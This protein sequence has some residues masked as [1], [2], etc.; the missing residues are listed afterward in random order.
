MIL[1][2]IFLK[3]TFKK[4]NFVDILNEFSNVFKEKNNE[5]NKEYLCNELI[6]LSTKNPI[7][8][9]MFEFRQK[10]DDKFRNIP[11]KDS[12]DYFK[13]HD[14]HIIW[15]DL[16]NFWFTYYTSIIQSQNNI[17][18]LRNLLK[19]DNN[20]NG[21]NNSLIWLNDYIKFMKENSLKIEQYK[22]FPNQMGNFEFINDL[23]Y[24][25][26]IPEILINIYNKLIYHDIRNSFLSKQITSYKNCD[27]YTKELIIA[28][29]EKNYKSSDDIQLKI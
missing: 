12:N 8:K 4:K 2:M 28:Q 20:D 6:S 13:N 21:K 26:S 16:K 22:I 7:V 9:Q 17:D 14:N 25:D 29:I 19:Y 24:E 10:T 11:I 1:I 27:K 3:N 5:E 23:Y 15:E 18:G